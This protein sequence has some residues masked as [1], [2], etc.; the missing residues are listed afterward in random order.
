MICLLCY[1]L[2]YVGVFCSLK[3]LSYIGLFLYNAVGIIAANIICL[4]LYPIPI[5]GINIPCG[6][7]VFGS[8]FAVNVILEKRF[9]YDVAKKCIYSGFAYYLLFALTM[10]LCIF[11]PCANNVGTCINMH[12]EIKAIFSFSVP[13]FF[14]SCIA[15]FVSQFLNIYVFAKLRRI[16]NNTTTSAIVSMCGSTVVDN[17]V[18]SVFAW[19]IFA[20]EK[21]AWGDLFTTYFLNTILVRIFVALS[22]VPLVKFCL[23]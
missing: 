14:A 12:D 16:I 2:A 3:W 23:R 18:F 17:F 4:K 15:Y 21:V 13:F 20:P 19:N 7:I 6:N 8:L 9:G 10:Q 22:F 1:L 5:F 11:I